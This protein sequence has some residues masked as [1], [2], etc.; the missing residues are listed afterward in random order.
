MVFWGR[1]R[2][3]RCSKTKTKQKKKQNKNKTKTVETGQA[4]VRFTS[5]GTFLVRITEADGRKCTLALQRQVGCP[6]GYVVANGGCQPIARSDICAGFAVKDQAGTL[7][8]AGRTGF[9]VG[10]RLQ[11]VLDSSK[12]SMSMYQFE[13][14]PKQGK[15]TGNATDPVS[16]DQPGSFSLDL[17]YTPPDGP[18]V[19]CPALLPTV[20]VAASRSCD[21]LQATFVLGS[22]SA[23]GAT[24]SL[25]ASVSLPA[26]LN[27]T[28]IASPQDSSVPVHLSPSAAKSSS[29]EGSA[30][31][32]STGQWAVAAYSGLEPCVLQSQVLN[33]SCMRG[34]EDDGQS[35]RCPQG[36]ENI[37][38]EC[39]TVQQREPCE[40]A[41]VRSFQSSAPAWKRFGYRRHGRLGRPRYGH[42]DQWV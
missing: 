24:S 42:D 29:W 34:F 12:A 35:C 23:R 15:V 41:V 36:L 17:A 22:S 20:D 33:V 37:N 40:Q 8:V 10:D 32:P 3:P 30:T 7:V 11:V 2:G 38:G 25:R 21:K 4:T 19:R 5:P 13:L 18:S 16:L 27:P 39:K 28:V 14:V 9:T 6:A 26:G 1:T 31:L